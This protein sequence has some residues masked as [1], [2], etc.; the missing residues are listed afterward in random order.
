M[1]CPRCWRV[2]RSTAANADI[3]AALADLEKLPANVRAPASAWIEKA[4]ARQAAID[5]AR[6]F[7]ADATR[8]LGKP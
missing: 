8:G 6:R 5:A 3:A 2:S 1:T 4:K 7:A